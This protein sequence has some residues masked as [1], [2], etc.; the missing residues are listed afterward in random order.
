MKFNLEQSSLVAQ[1]E[2]TFSFILALIIYLHEYAW[3]FSSLNYLLL[4]QLNPGK[5]DIKT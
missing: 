5:S 3:K 2:I 1:L 4:F